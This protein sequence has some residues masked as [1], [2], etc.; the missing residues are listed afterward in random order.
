[1]LLSVH[2]DQ[3]NPAILEIFS[4]Y[5]YWYSQQVRSAKGRNKMGLWL[6]TQVFSSWSGSHP[7]MTENGDYG[8]M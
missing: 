3:S 7:P 2:N 6:H 8:S 1:M 5:Q 4:F